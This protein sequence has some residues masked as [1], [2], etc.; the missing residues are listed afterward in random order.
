VTAE[1]VARILTEHDADS[2]AY[3]AELADDPSGENDCTV[4]WSTGG[5]GDEFTISLFG[6][7][8][9]VADPSGPDP[10]PIQGIGDD[11][12][13]VDGNY[14]ARVGDRMI[15]IVNVQEGD[16]T[17]EAL[18]TLAAHRLANS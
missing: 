7:N 11:A 17:D 4:R 5:S 10:R 1:D 14:Y 15:H 2:R 12:F 13:E 18:L 16:G 6:A 8:G 3:T 9:Y